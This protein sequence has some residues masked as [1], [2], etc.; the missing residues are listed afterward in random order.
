MLMPNRMF[1]NAEGRFFQD[2]TTSAGVGH[3]QKSHAVAVGDVNNDGAPDMYVVIGGEYP[4]DT[5]QRSLFLNPGT[6]NHWV[7]LK[8]EG[9]ESNRSAI[10][11]RI[12]VSVA[13]ETGP[14]DIYRTVSSGGS[15]GASTL[16]QEVGLG[17][18][19]AIR[20]IKVTWP[21]TG[22]V[23]IFKDVGMDQMVRI[24]EGDSA[25][26]PMKARPFKI[27]PDLTSRHAH[28]H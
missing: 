7:T 16:R 4:G 2:V 15:F 10:G 18:A 14:R 3:L 27:S 23:Q 12:K 25:V 24:R 6:S 9:V 19:T 1:R 17:R 13:T 21:R 20:S 11:A 8:L 5:F 22:R 28:P 26:I